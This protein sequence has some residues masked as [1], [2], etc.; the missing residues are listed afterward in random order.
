LNAELVGAHAALSPDVRDVPWVS[1]CAGEIFLA[2]EGEE[3]LRIGHFQGDAA[4][5]AFVVKAHNNMLPEN[6]AA[7]GEQS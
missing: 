2:T 7:K 3:A 1:N 4:L 5:A 6:P